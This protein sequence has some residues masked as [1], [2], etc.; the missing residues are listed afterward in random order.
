MRIIKRVI[1]LFAILYALLCV[2][3][4]FGQERLIFH[5][6]KLPEDF[7]FRAGEEVELGVD[8]GISLNGLWLKEPDPKGV[9]LYLHGNRGSNRRCLR[10][11]QTMAGNGYDIFMPDYRGFGKS[12][13]TIETEAQLQS[14]VQKAYDFLKKSYPEERIVLVGYSLGSGLAA[15]LAANNH[16]RQLVL[17]A[18]YL[19]M[20]DMKDRVA[21]FLPDFLLKYH[22]TNDVYLGK[23][24]LPITI[25]HGEADDVIPVESSRKL[26]ALKPAGIRLVTMRGV[27]HRGVIFNQ[28]FRNGIRE[29]LR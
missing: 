2:A 19:S 16:P 14:D 15:Y 3:L 7:V 20:V 22:L 6:G 26:K 27:G 17:L 10:Q 1:A 4:F 11:A 18:P 23:A 28:A 5:P 8:E 13:G 12:G 25:F 9:I 24:D 21:P 29:L